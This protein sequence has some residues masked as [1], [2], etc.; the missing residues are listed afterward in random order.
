MTR[1]IELSSDE[2]LAELKAR[3][4]KALE[5]DKTTVFSLCEVFTGVPAHLDKHGTGVLAWHAR[6][7]DGKVE[8]IEG[9]ASDVT[10]KTV[11]DY[12]FIVPFARARL[13]PENAAEMTARME[14][15][16]AAGKLHREGDRSQVPLWFHAIHNDLADITA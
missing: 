7:A 12:D 4:E 3:I 2:W 10:M 15:G 14:E 8:F 13:G 9:E 5:T 16:A 6:I 1:K 11:C